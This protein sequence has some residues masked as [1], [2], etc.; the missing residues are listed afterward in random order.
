M[1]VQRNKDITR[2][3]VYRTPATTEYFFE[4]SDRAELSILQQA[5]AEAKVANLPIIFVAGGTNVVF[6]FDHF[7][8]LIVHM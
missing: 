6:A 5:I 2:L 3:S 7:P 4:L 8:G 1:E